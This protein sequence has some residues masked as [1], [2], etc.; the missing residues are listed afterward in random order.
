MKCLLTRQTECLK[1]KLSEDDDIRKSPCPF[2]LPLPLLVL[3]PLFSM[4]DQLPGQ[5]CSFGKILKF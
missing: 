1:V 3:L 2:L 4:A 5:L